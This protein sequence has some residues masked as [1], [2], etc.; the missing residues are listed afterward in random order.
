M[1]ITISVNSVLTE[2][3]VKL[4]IL[5][6]KMHFSICYKIWQIIFIT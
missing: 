3:N 6:K 4:M 1:V 5:L 2:K